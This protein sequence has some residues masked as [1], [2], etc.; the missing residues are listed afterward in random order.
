MIL[1]L[2]KCRLPVTSLVLETENVFEGSVIIYYQMLSFEIQA[3]IF[4]SLES[5]TER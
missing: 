3:H 1:I 2:I 4:T 5:I